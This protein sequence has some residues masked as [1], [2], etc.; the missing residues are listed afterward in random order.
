MGFFKIYEESIFPSYF[1]KYLWRKNFFHHR[2]FK[3]YEWKNWSFIL[4]EESH[5]FQSYFLELS[6][7]LYKKKLN[8]FNWPRVYEGKMWDTHMY[9]LCS[10]T[11]NNCICSEKILKSTPQ[12]VATYAWHRILKGSYIVNC[13]ISH[14]DLHFNKH[15]IIVTCGYAIL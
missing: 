3:N 7:K 10:P 4:F 6:M 13:F 15:S 12:T 8:I 1:L 11:L 9:I 14:F 2:Y 5:S